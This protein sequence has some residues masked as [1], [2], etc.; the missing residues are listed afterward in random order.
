MQVQAFDQLRAE[1]RATRAV[2]DVGRVTEVSRA[3]IT[4]SG[5]Q[6]VASLGDQVRWISRNWRS[7][8]GEIVRL[9]SDGAHVM[10][11]GSAEGISVGDR[12][13]HMGPCE[14]APDE[15]WLGRIVDPLGRPLDGRPLWIQLAHL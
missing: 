15:S 14:I 2:R 11:A 5:L 3:M 7:L 12:V 10:M 9:G 4:V 13:Q 6:K 1:V 8:S